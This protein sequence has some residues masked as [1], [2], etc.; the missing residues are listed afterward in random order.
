MA[1][2]DS[3]RCA[4]V[5]VMKCEWTGKSVSE[6]VVSVAEFSL[7]VWSCQ[8]ERMR[9]CVCVGCVPIRRIS[10]FLRAKESM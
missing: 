3:V 9:S 1:V 6:C 7:P 4:R 2:F 10:D 8:C 5:Y